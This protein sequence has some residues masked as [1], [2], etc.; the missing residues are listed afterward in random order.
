MRFCEY[1]SRFFCCVCH[2]NTLMVLP[3]PV[4]LDGNFAM[5]P[6]SNYA[7]DLLDRL[8]CVP[9]IRLYEISRNVRD[10]E[11]ALQDAIAMREQAGALVAFLGLCPSSKSFVFSQEKEVPDFLLSLTKILFFNHIN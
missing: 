7:R 5:L 11:W 6:V 4:V 3:G 2:S 8:H 9:L 10:R 1:F